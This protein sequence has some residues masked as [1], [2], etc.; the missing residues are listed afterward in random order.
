MKFR[1]TVDGADSLERRL[2]R[3]VTD[4]EIDASLRVGAEAIRS[5]ARDRLA[6]EPGAR[7]LADGIAIERESNGDVTRYRIGSE[8]AAAVAIEYGTRAR[9]GSPFLLPAFVAIVSNIRAM[10]TRALDRAKRS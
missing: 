4:A 1:A 3:L 10:F 8:D 5:E 7:A 6:G 2:M 9:P